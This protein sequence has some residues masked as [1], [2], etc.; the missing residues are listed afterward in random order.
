[1]DKFGYCGE[2]KVAKFNGTGPRVTATVDGVRTLIT[3]NT[4]Q[5][6]Y[7]GDFEIILNNTAPITGEQNIFEF[8]VY[9][10]YDVTP[11]TSGKDLNF[12]AGSEDSATGHTT[13][14]S[15]QNQYQVN[16]CVI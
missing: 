2:P 1:M 8:V 15:M 14:K 13:L 7:R 3:R 10:L 6:L 12:T 4:I 11:Q 16:I 9:V 5:P